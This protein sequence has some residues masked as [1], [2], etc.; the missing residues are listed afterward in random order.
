MLAATVLPIGKHDPR[1]RRDIDEYLADAAG[2]EVLAARL[3]QAGADPAEFTACWRSGAA[4]SGFTCG[5]CC[6]SCGSGCGAR[7]RSATLPAGLRSYYADQIRRWQ[8][9]PA[10]DTALLPLL[11]TLG[12][13]G[14]PLPA[15]SLARLA[16]G[17][18]P[19][20]VQRWCDLTIRPLLTTTRHR[21]AG[22]PLRYEIYHASFRELLNGYPDDSPGSAG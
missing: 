1:N 3:A 21:A 8:Q 22:A 20:A 18:D 13:A 6:T 11:A 19:A 16:G 17:L 9:D 2:E 12:V 10:W 14:E 5:T 15:A 4:A 7:M